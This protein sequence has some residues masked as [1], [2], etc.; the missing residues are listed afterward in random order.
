MAMHFSDIDMLLQWG[1]LGDHLRVVTVEGTLLYNT[2]TGFVHPSLTERQVK[3]IEEDYKR[4]RK[5]YVF[6]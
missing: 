3:W 5:N 6:A 4:K 1:R 2:A